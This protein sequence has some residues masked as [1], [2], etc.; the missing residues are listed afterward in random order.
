MTS[1]TEFVTWA[2]QNV[3]REVPC[4]QPHNLADG[5]RLS[6][7][8]V[9]QLRFCRTCG[10]G[11]VNPPGT[12]PN[13]IWPLVEALTK[14]C[15]CDGD[16]YCIECRVALTGDL[17]LHAAKC[18]CHGTGL[19]PSDLVRLV[20]VREDGT[21]PLGGHPAVGVLQG[22]VEAAGLRLLPVDGYS[23]CVYEVYDD[24]GVRGTGTGNT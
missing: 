24:T 22:A 7:I 9:E 12:I 17:F 3:P 14:P 21:W 16:N 4:P 11:M 19:V 20:D 5:K 18:R 23:V 6:E 15:P 1:I 2:A 13:P 8:P 10:E